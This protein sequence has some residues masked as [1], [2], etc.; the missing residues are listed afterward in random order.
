MVGIKIGGILYVFIA[1]FVL[2]VALV[3]FCYAQG[4][5]QGGTKE[6][7]QPT[8]PP[9]ET[10][11]QAAATPAAPDRPTVNINT[12]FYSKYVWRG[13]ELSKDSF[14]MFPQVTV[15]YK[16]FS[17][18][19]WGDAD[20]H[21]YGSPDGTQ[22]WEQDYIAF[23]TNTYKMLNYTLGYIYYHTKTKPEGNT[24]EVW[25]SLGLTNW[26]NPTLSVWRDIARGE[27]WY[28][29]FA[30]SHSFPIPKDRFG[31]CRDWSFDI[32]TWVSYYYQHDYTRFDTNYSTW[33]DGNVWFNVKVPLSDVC[34]IAPTFQYSYPLTDH[35]RSNISNSSFEGDKADYVYGGLIFD[36]NF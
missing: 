33:H 16:G 30:V 35:S 21:Y 32:G 22:M 24:Q 7:E 13:Y 4:E 29:N 20:T 5:A 1:M 14:V 27:S 31:L 28:Y 34:S 2:G 6:V 8:T 17:L 3:P 9:G 36:Y 19:W 10:A 11:Q 15:S 18:R 12:S 26:F 23:Y 25:V